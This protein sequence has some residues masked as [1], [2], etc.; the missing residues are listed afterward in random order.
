GLRK[1]VDQ[2]GASRQR[3]EA[4]VRG[5]LSRGRFA[6]ALVAARR[7]ADLDPDAQIARDLLAAAAAA[8]GDAE[9]A[10]TALDAGLEAS[11]RNADLHG[12]AAR[13]FEAAGDEARA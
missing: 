2:N 5:L 4:L 8:T 12:R 3:H 10:R 9:L 11:P 6:E 13:A 7:F 1:A